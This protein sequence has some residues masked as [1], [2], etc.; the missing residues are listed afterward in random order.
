MNQNSEVER[1]L[2][3]A[4]LGEETTEEDIKKAM[5][6]AKNANTDKP[7]LKIANKFMTNVI[8]KT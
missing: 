2:I 6:D 4:M 7:L 8:I 5:K 3:E 1:L